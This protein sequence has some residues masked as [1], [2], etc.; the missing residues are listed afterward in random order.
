MATM[1]GSPAVPSFE[2]GGKTTEECHLWLNVA[3][4]S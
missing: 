1:A 3:E 4:E 2:V